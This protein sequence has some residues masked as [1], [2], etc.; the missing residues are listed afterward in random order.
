MWY[1]I[2]S[3]NQL[4]V[5]TLLR[6]TKYL[7]QFDFLELLNSSFDF[8]GVPIPILGLILIVIIFIVL[9]VI[10]ML[11][12]R[13]VNK[14]IEHHMISPS[15]YNGVRFLMRIIFAVA[16]AEVCL[17][18]LQ[19]ESQYIL[20]ISGII[21]TAMAFA[22]AKTINNFVSGF[23]VTITRLVP[24]GDYLRVDNIEGIVEDISLN[25]TKIRTKD[26]NLIT[27]SNSNLMNSTVINYTIS[28]KDYESSISDLE[29]VLQNLSKDVKEGD[30]E[31]G[32]KILLAKEELAFKHAKLEEFRSI[33]TSISK[34][35]APRN[36]SYSQYVQ[37]DKIVRYTFTINLTRNP[38]RNAP[39]LDEL[40]QKWKP[41]FGIA[42]RW[43]II[44]HTYF[45][46]YQFTIFTPDPQDIAR[47]YSEFIKDMYMAL[48]SK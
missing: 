14:V 18:F 29:R 16:I 23:W 35:S 33:S 30:K 40:C 8:F 15:L 21:A 10:Y 3:I 13:G 43:R 20:L 26:G 32:Q 17:V 6:G 24:Q 42:P 47:Y 38:A 5:V 11:V 28:L 25:F 22:S 45:L 19:I 27:F 39:L 31:K 4:L 9:Y 48:H 7:H 2:S 44:G 1:Y 41:I 36:H 12:L 46:L 34:K 37:E